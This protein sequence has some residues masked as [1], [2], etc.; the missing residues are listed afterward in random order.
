[1]NIYRY[2]FLFTLGLLSYLP[3]AFAQEKP[4]LGR[5]MPQLGQDTLP[6]T[7]TLG[8]MPDSLTIDNI[9]S[10]KTDNEVKFSDNDL[11]DELIYSARDSQ[12][13]DNKAGLMHLYGEAY[14][15]YQDKELTADLIILDIE[16][17]IAEA[18]ISPA[19]KK[20]KKPTFK[21]GEKEYKYNRLKYNFETEKGIVYDA[22][23][24]EGE[25]TVHGKKTKYV[26][27][28]DNLYGNSDVIYNANSIITTCN[29]PGTPHFGF[30]AKKLKVVSDKVAVAGPSNLQ[31]SGIPTPVW[32]PFAFFPLTETTSTGLIFPE[33]FQFF[34]RDLGFG[35]SGIGW[36]FPINDYVHTTIT[37]DIWSLGTHALYSNTTYRKKYRYS[38]SVNLSYNNFRSENEELIKVSDKGFAF[39]LSH[40]Q[41]GKAHPYRT[42]G[43]SINIIGND[44][45]SRVNNDAGS[46]L[47][48]S[49]TSNFSFTHKMPR[50]PFS[51]RLGMSHNQ[52]TRTNVMNLTLPD[53]ALT[54]ST[55]YPFALK[56]TG[57]NEKKWFEKIALGYNS[58]LRV[59]TS[60]TDTTLFTRETIENTQ[61]GITHD[62][63]LSFSNRVF[64]YFNIVPNANYNE[65][66][67]LNTIDN[68]IIQS[69]PFR[70]IGPTPQDTLDWEVDRIYQTRDSLI[71]SILSNGGAYRT[72]SAGVSIS[73]Q[74]YGTKTFAKGPIRGIRHLVKPSLTYG[75]SPDQRNQIDTIFYGDNRSLAY[76]QF[77]QG[78]FGNPNFGNLR[79]QVSYRIGNVLEM[80]YFSKKDSTERKFKIFDNVTASGSY[81]FAL[82]SLKWSRKSLRSTSRLFGG[83]TQVSSNWTFD[84]YLAENG[85]RVNKTVWSDRKKLARLVSGDV[86]A[87]TRISFTQIRKLLQGKDKSSDEEE[88][89]EIDQGAYA[90]ANLRGNN[91]PLGQ[92][93]SGGHEGHNH[94]EQAVKPK[95]KSIFD[96][97]ERLSFRHNLRYTVTGDRGSRRGEITTHSID[98]TGQFNLT[99]NWNINIG[100]LGYDF[101]NKGPTYSTISF[102]RKLHCWDMH[103]TWTPSRN[104]LYSFFIGVNSGALSFLKYNYGQNNTDAF[105]NNPLGG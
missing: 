67:V 69:Q 39:R 95:H 24:T 63:N 14:V 89:I 2:I 18:L 22:I 102:I 60:T 9:G 23:T 56:N 51:F 58:R 48:S 5:A 19:K 73:T 65:T 44:N 93:F 29:H 75:Y 32:L 54:M 17:N 61:A 80:K 53:A 87:S 46:V 101:A 50:T 27:G 40:N 4:E 36:Y 34:S 25:F 88:D 21:D 85:R 10:E 71:T 6:V 47:T 45:V 96:L 90:D 66:W 104:N 15:K 13:Y 62:L 20:A 31:I 99:D 59:S 30:N 35:V 91:S 100:S 49:Y 76:S 52:N 72:F 41:D 12:R 86:S 70:E 105:F 94:E 33:G 16:N 3:D 1:M 97:L 43:G 37:A 7:T 83:M 84:P 78:P 98:V 68:Q 81:N 79:S 28:G 74:V 64:K 77:D 55:I 92:D 103:I 11:E 82:D 42:L 38:G 26:S 57:G 8:G